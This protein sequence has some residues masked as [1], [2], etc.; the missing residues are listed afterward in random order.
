MVCPKCQTQQ[1]DSSRFCQECGTSLDMRVSGGAPTAPPS[2]GWGASPP[3]APPSAAW[4]GSAPTVPQS[5]GWGGTPAAASASAGWGGAPAPAPPSAGW[6]GTPPPAP[7]DAGPGWGPLPTPGPQGPT[8]GDQVTEGV[9]QFAGALERAGV[10][11]GLVERVQGL[12]LNPRAEWARIR[13]EQADVQGLVLRY[14]AVLSLIPLVVHVLVG[15]VRGMRYSG[16]SWIL[17]RSIEGGIESYV[18]GLIGVVVVAWILQALGPKF[19]AACDLVQATKVTVYAST[20][21]WIA[22]VAAFLI[23]LPG[24]GRLA[25]LVLVAGGIYGLYLVWLGVGIVL[26]PRPE[27]LMIYVIVALVCTCVVFAVIGSLAGGLGGVYTM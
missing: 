24:I 9:Y 2:G 18:F 6:G 1:D 10:P 4:G 25:G 26:R 21:S 14:A 13:D 7:Q 11:A 15:F 5:G 8:L 3:P 27:Q 19:G 16:A 22:S 20:P 12:F 23:L 17:R